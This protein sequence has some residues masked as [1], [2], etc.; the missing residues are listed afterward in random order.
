[1]SV[2]DNCKHYVLQSV[3]LSDKLERCKLKVNTDLPFACPS[4]CLFFEARAG[5][6]KLGW[7]MPDKRKKDTPPS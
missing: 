6:S 2:R 3:S 7:K 5:I 4:D 1:V